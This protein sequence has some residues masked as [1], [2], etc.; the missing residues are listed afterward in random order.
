MQIVQIVQAGDMR[1]LVEVSDPAME[2][3]TPRVLK[4]VQELTPSGL[5]RLMTV[6]SNTVTAGGQTRTVK[7]FN[8]ELGAGQRWAILQ[9]I[10]HPVGE[11]VAGGSLCPVV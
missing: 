2:D 5:A 7:G 9:I 8:Y 1:R 10:V 6:N 3:F 4:Q 11:A